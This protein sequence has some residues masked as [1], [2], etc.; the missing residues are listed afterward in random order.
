MRRTMKTILMT[1]KR[2]VF[3]NGNLLAIIGPQYSANYYRGIVTDRYPRTKYE[4]NW[5]ET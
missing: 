4:W 3:I 1:R 5:K 2:F